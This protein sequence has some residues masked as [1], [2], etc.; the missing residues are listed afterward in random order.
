MII[1]AINL[2]IVITKEVQYADAILALA[3]LVK[4]NK[5]LKQI[6]HSKNIEIHTIQNNSLVQITKALT[7][8]TN[9]NFPKLTTN[10]TET[11]NRL[12]R[13]YRQ[14]LTPL[15]ETRLI[16][17]DI[18]IPKNLIVDLSPQTT[19]VR[20]EQYDL[21]AHYQLKSITVGNEKQRKLRIY[22]NSLL[23]KK[24]KKG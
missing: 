22:P 8:L 16:I 13:T 15:E 11:L 4:N 1:K 23:D 3:N 19:K 14:F 18:V 2:P 9:K 17:E 20:K 7:Q 21:I 12:K 6:S 10:K 5:K 24:E